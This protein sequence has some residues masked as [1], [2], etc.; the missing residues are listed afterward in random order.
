MAD[1][2]I[3]EIDQLG[4]GQ[5]EH[6]IRRLDAEQIDAL[7]QHER[8]HGNRAP[9]LT[10]LEGRLQQLA[11]GAQP[12]DADGLSRPSD[13][14]PGPGTTSGPVS[15]ATEAEPNPPDPHGGPGRRQPATRRTT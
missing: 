6:R 2:A 3:P 11:E 14:P 5:L 13:T 4:P 15:E 8:E 1:M 9:V 12:T 10:I 7:V